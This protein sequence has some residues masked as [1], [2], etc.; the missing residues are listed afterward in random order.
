LCRGASATVTNSIIWG[1]TSP[2][3]REI[4]VEDAASTLTIAY[5]D[6]AGGQAGI[7]VESGCTLDW[8]EG[9]ID[10]D[11]C[12]AD[13]ANDDYHLKS[14]AGRWDPTTQAWGQDDV[15]SSCIDAGDPDSDW[16]AEL[17]PH[18]IRTNMGAYGGTLQA[19]RSLSDA[20]NIADVDRDA[21]VDS[22]DMCMMVD[23]WHTDQPYCD[24]AP[25]PFGDDIVDVQ[26]LVVLAENLFEDYRMIAHWKL[27][28]T[29]GGVAYDSAA[30]LASIV[31]GNPAWQPTGGMI[32]GA[33]EFDGIDDYVETDFVLSPADGPFSVFAWIKGGAPGQAVL[34][35][36]GGANWLSA[37]SL[38]GNLMTELKGHGRG[39][40]EILSQTIITD[41]NWH[42]VG[43]VWNGSYRI[44]YV[45]DVEAARDTK[46]WSSL[47]GSDSGLYIGCG[48]AME[49]GTYWSGLIDDVRIYNRA[50]SP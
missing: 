40:S 29:G 35:Q 26:D 8:G 46:T 47:T 37:D 23:H 30:D 16:R 4:S 3:G 41:D 34:S 28:E 17:W 49:A 1:N 7:Y 2:K 12:F 6:V 44:L 13:P 11:P 27:D 45:D 15:T 20:G 33:L 25:V 18:G 19:S 32:D 22:A 5:N 21:I 48:K 50:V 42:R 36:A 9:N 14:E 39:A 43:F 31:H 10:A 24:I 38:E